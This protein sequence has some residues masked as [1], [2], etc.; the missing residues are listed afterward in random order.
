MHGIGWEGSVL[1]YLTSKILYNLHFIK[2]SIIYC[3]RQ[4]SFWYN[5]FK[6]Y[7]CLVC[8]TRR[9]H[10][11]RMCLKLWSVDTCIRQNPI[12]NGLCWFS[13]WVFLMDR[14]SGSGS[15]SNFDLKG[16][17]T[18]SLILKSKRQFTIHNS[19][20]VNW[21]TCIS[22]LKFEFDKSAK[23]KTM[24]RTCITLKQVKLWIFYPD[25]MQKRKFVI[26]RQIRQIFENY[27]DVPYI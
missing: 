3:I 24:L 4:I 17:V 8:T 14:S 16:S 10:S 26:I 21:S 18:N 19:I 7:P 13:L 6:A 5:F 23:L 22:S 9:N 27:I 1:F 20:T 2:S 12:A 11:A 15:V 25:V